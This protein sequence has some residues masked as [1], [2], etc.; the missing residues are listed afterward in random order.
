[1]TETELPEETEELE[2]LEELEE[3]EKR[4]ES[5]FHKI[6]QNKNVNSTIILSTNSFYVIGFAWSCKFIYQNINEIIIVFMAMS[7]S[8]CTFFVSLQ[9][10]DLCRNIKNY[11]LETDKKDK[12]NEFLEKDCDLFQGVYSNSELKKNEY[13]N[14]DEMFLKELSKVDF[15]YHTILPFNYNAE[16]ILYYDYENKTFNYFAKNSDIHYKFLNS[17]CRSY[18]LKYHCVNLFQDELD[19]K[20]F[21]SNEEEEE[22]YEKIEEEEEEEEFE[23]KTTRTSVF[24]IKKTR[25]E[26]EKNKKKDLKEKTINK[27]LYK[28]NMGEYFKLYLED[29]SEISQNINYEDYKQLQ[30]NESEHDKDINSSEDSSEDSV[31][32]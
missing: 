12:I 32:L 25:T 21:S 28:G 29:K 27:F 6:R 1:M 15:H 18:V 30:T 23:T 31:N 22:D 4:Q 13:E 3:I 19:I 17:V 10:Y 24:Y 7:C 11:V 20:Q 9:L 2:E 8:M 26:K 5:L 14:N 16:V